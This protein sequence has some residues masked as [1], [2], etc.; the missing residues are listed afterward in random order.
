MGNRIRINCRKVFDNGV[1]YEK[2]GEE[3]ESIQ[4]DLENIYETLDKEWSGVDDHNFLVS[5]NRHINDMNQMIGFL[6]TNGDLLKKN[7]L[8][9]N[10]IDNNFAVK[11]ERSDMNEHE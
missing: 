10:G 3:I 5:F 4:K 8:E 9:H 11:M 6:A 2:T 1:Y 7:A